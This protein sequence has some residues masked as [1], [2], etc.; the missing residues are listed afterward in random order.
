[1]SEKHRKFISTVIYWGLVLLLCWVSIRYVLLWLLPFLLALG[2]ASIMEPTVCFL[3]EK[4]RL[5]RGFIS[6]ILSFVLLA[7]LFAVLTVLL[8]N[9][10]QQTVR[11]FRALPQY[12]AELPAYFSAMQRRLEQFCASC[13]QSM[14][15][16]MQR[17]I[18][19]VSQQISSWFTRFSARCVS[20]AADAL[21]SLPSAFLFAATT[22]LAIFFT[23][24]QFPSVMAFLRRQL[25]PQKL[26]KA[27][28]VKKNLL[29][30]L[31]KWFKAQCI[32]LSVT[33]SELLAGFV[34][35]RQPYALLLAAVIAVIDAL[36]V[37]GTGTVLLPW[38]VV[39]LLL[40]QMPKAIALGILYAVI[41]LVRSFLEP[42][43]M[44]AQVNLPPLA[45]LMAM[46]IGF[47]A[48][49]VGGM[50]LFPM[51]LLFLKQLRDAGYLNLWK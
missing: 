20:A 42:K 26:Q 29:S 13:P 24:S 17:A 14:Q 33:F 15:G 40:Q 36:P 22:V 10:M 7:L 48:L 21:S 1:M 37:F 28:G 30:T 45:A 44:A 32:L 41:S 46:Y 3:R 5:R 47:C 25:P 19:D 27:G 43:V 16:W 31:T 4:L 38:A 39:C 50:I 2:V 6:A 12:L 23:A 34:I 9:L 11:L 18:D 8:M 35:I 49:G 51:L